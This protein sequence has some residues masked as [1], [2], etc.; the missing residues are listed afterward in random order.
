MSV[1]RGPPPPSTLPSDFESET[2]GAS[3]KT[4]T[5]LFDLSADSGARLGTNSVRQSPGR[6]GLAPGSRRGVVMGG[7]LATALVVFA[8]MLVCS[9]VLEALA[10]DH[11]KERSDSCSVAALPSQIWR[12]AGRDSR[13]SAGMGAIVIDGAQFVLREANSGYLVDFYC[14]CVHEAA[15]KHARCHPPVAPRVGVE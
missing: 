13:R 11:C 1:Q 9:V 4:K 14:C 2:S 12:D 6:Q 15:K 5:S 10:A 7:G 3:A 8:A